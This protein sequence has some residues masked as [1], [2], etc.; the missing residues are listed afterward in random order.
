MFVD[1]VESALRVYLTT[2]PQTG[3]LQRSPRRG[4]PV[5]KERRIKELMQS[6]LSRKLSPKLLAGECGL[7][8]RHF[9]RAFTLST[10]LSPRRYLLKLRIERARQLLMCPDLPLNEIAISCG[11]ADQSHF[12]RAFGATENMSP[13]AWR[14]LTA[15]RAG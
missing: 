6:Q 11:F 7:S 4:L 13:G 2:Y 14:R 5:W 9:T 12:T 3:T 1:Q 10:G 8:I 15:A